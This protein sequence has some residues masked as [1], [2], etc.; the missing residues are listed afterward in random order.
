MKSFYF[1]S[2]KILLIGIQQVLQT[3]YKERGSNSA[4]YS[5][6]D[7]RVS[8]NHI[9]ESRIKLQNTTHITIVH[10]A[11]TTNLKDL[12]TPKSTSF[13]QYQI[14]QV[15]VAFFALQRPSQ[16]IFKANTMSH[17][18]IL[19]CNSISTFKS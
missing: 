19:Y 15:L 16:L 3:K 10:G 7:C 8:P 1:I 17:K 5:I 11:S 14:K 9:L 4:S 13:Y 6:K 12:L 18:M 2:K